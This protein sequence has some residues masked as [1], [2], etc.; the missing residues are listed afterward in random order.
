MWG[1][2]LGAPFANITELRLVEHTDVGPTDSDDF[3]AAG[4]DTMSSKDQ[5]FVYASHY[6]KFR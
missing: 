5:G 3:V 4:T 6:Y 2:E 1:T